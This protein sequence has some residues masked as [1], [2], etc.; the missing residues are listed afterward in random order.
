M[1][2]ASF[3]TLIV[4]LCTAIA[5]CSGKDYRTYVSKRGE[6]TLRYPARWKAMDDQ[7]KLDA[8]TKELTRKVGTYVN[9]IDLE[10][11]FRSRDGIGIVARDYMP[12]ETRKRDTLETL[13]ESEKST[14][15]K[16]NM[17]IRNINGRDFLVITEEIFRMNSITAYCMDGG[18]IYSFQFACPK[19]KAA[20]WE[21]RLA[22]CV[23]SISF[24]DADIAQAK[25]EQSHGKA[26]FF[27]GLWHGYLI[28]FR[29]VAVSL[30]DFD[31]YASDNTGAGYMIGFIIGALF[32][33][34]HMVNARRKR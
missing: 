31:L 19:D 23:E 7:T 9:D 6:Y 21:P 5:G 24:R 15:R 11:V 1:K 22:E 12:P 29:W 17:R 2:R 34:T 8:V 3:I 13:K 25:K 32:F 14:Y 16:Q 10:V 4:L 18:N 28:P 27:S 20:K 26:G 33:L 30:W